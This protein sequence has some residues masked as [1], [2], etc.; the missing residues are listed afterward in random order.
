M[1]VTLRRKKL[2]NNKESLYLDIYLPETGKKRTKEYLKLYLFS[3][4]KTKLEKEANKETLLLAESIAAKKLLQLQDENYGIKKSFKTD[5]NF[6][7]YFRL[8][9]EKRVHS[10]GNQNNWNSTLRQII[11]FSGEFI[12]FKEVNEQWVESFKYFLKNES[13]TINNTNLSQNSCYTYFNKI[14][15]SLRL[16]YKDKIIPYNPAEH[17]PSFKQGDSQREFLTFEEVQKLAQTECSNLKLKTA[18]MFSALTG[19]RWSD[20]NKL[21]WS[22][23][24]YSEALGYYLR[25]T[26]A[27][28]KGAETQPISDQA[29]SLLGERKEPSTRV[30]KGLSYSAHNNLRLRQWVLKAGITKDITFH[31]ARHTYATLQLTLGT[32]I[33]TVSKLLGHKDIKTTQVYAK[34][35][36][37]KKVEAANKIPHIKF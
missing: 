10:S 27:K 25:F 3:K 33:Y 29:F 18:F 31:C 4:P 5:T 15:A 24:Q 23:V 34:I 35:I 28:T 21:T 7:D 8:Q 17:I 22:E 11:K 12:P 16:A 37:E 30:F 2:K 26:Q 6:V 32:D 20:I 1:K 19:L 36:N 14:K 13:K 9:T